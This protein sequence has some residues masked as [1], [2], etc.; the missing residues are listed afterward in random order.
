M[1]GR[2][3]MPAS[4][5]GFD[6]TKDIEDLKRLDPVIC[7]FGKFANSA[8]RCGNKPVSI[9]KVV[10]PVTHYGYVVDGYVVDGYFTT[11]TSPTVDQVA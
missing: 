4:T 2:S 6:K 3:N 5:V 9:P 7:D 8:V 1:S 11:S 10:P